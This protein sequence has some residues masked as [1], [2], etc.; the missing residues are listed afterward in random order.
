MT[1]KEEL[2]DLIGEAAIVLLHREIRRHGEVRLSTEDFAQEELARQRGQEIQLDTNLSGD[3]IF[4]HTHQ[5]VKRP[6]S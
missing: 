1:S 2:S 5:D 6:V 4:R 3:V